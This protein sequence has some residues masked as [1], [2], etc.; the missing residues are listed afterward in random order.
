MWTASVTML[1]WFL[2]AILSFGA[3]HTK[4]S[5][6]LLESPR[7]I[8]NWVCSSPVFLFSELAILRETLQRVST[9]W[10]FLEYPRMIEN[11]FRGSPRIFF[12]NISISLKSLQYKLENCGPICQSFSEILRISDKVWYEML[13]NLKWLSKI[14]GASLNWNA[15]SDSWSGLDKTTQA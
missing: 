15:R 8:V 14:K 12:N 5:R 6:I 9:S 7:R 3:S 4:P 1:L 11:W 2:A 10:R 13:Q